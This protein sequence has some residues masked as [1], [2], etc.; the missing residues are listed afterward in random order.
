[1]AEAELITTTPLRRYP[2]YKEILEEINKTNTLKSEDNLVIN[3]G[4]RR[5][6]KRWTSAATAHQ[7]A[8]INDS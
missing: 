5:E 4:E 3:G 6:Q 7:E 1:M 8:A 2:P